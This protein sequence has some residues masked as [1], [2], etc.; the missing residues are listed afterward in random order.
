MTKTCFSGG[1]ILLNKKAMYFIYKEC[2]TSEFAVFSC[3][4]E[5]KFI[6]KCPI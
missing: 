3:K 5:R 2:K 1:V 6:V 4:F